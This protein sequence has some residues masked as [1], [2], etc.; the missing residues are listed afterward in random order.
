MSAMDGETVQFAIQ[1][2]HRLALMAL[3]VALF[4]LV[5]ELVRRDR[6]KERYAL[7]W[8][9]TSAFGLFVGIFPGLIEWAARIFRFQMLTLLF[10]AAFLFFLG[11]ILGHTV[12]ISRL[13]ER[14]RKLAQE[15]ALLSQR[16]EA[17]ERHD[18]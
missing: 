11:V 13:V 9:A 16:L 5:L 8:L 15:V 12:I 10:V 2:G 7:L 1:P 4:A 18:D 6:L 14:N 17:R 3:S